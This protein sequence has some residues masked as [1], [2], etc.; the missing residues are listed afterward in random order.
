MTVYTK[1]ESPIIHIPA[2]LSYKLPTYDVTVKSEAD[3]RKWEASGLTDNGRL[4]DFVMLELG[5]LPSL[6]CGDYTVE[7]G[8]GYSISILRVTEKKETTAHKNDIE[9]VV[10][11]G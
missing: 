8:D 11:N 7:V 6:P 10:Y 1:G 9:R 4:S 2:P 5:F 3:G